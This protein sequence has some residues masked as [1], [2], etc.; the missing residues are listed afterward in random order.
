MADNSGENSTQEI[1]KEI[2]AGK[3]G[4]SRTK[5]ATV[6]A[7]GPRAQNWNHHEHKTLV[8]LV[9]ENQILLFSDLSQSIT[10]RMKIDMW[11]KISESLTA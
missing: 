1:K 7:D 6:K 5:Q 9:V 8:K 2:N 11:K 3:K 4:G 10:A